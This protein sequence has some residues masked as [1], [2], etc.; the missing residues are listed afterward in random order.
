ASLRLELCGRPMLDESWSAFDQAVQSGDT[1]TR[2]A[3]NLGGVRVPVRLG[4][5]G[6]LADGLIGYFV[7]DGSTTLAPFYSG[8]GPPGGT[9]GV[10][11]LDAGK[12]AVKPVASSDESPSLM[13][14]MLVDPRG[15]VHATTGILP[16][17]DISIPADM[18]SDALGRIA[19]TFLT[20]PVIGGGPS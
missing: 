2:P 17:K 14:L 11:P 20:A 15:A 13:L 9:T 12:T 8:A 10:V 1:E 7:D 19:I 16:V 5:L 6:K 18:Y 3:A 4:D